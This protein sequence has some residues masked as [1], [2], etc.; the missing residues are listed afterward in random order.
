MLGFLKWTFLI[1]DFLNF[2]FLN[3]FFI[4]EF[5]IFHSCGWLWLLGKRDSNMSAEGKLGERYPNMGAEGCLASA[6]PIWA[7]KA[8][9]RARR[10]SRWLVCRC[11]YF[12]VILSLVVFASLLVCNQNILEKIEKFCREAKLFNFFPARPLGHARHT[13]VRVGKFPT[14]LFVLSWPGSA[15]ATPIWGP[16]AA[17]QARRWSW[18]FSSG[19][20]CP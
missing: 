16:K 6:I 4:F 5:F 11:D 17:R 1:F 8:A 15:S 9:R 10:R 2:P 19:L 12:R 20:F 13:K 18:C 3:L 7:P 14:G